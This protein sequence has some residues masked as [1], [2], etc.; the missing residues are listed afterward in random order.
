MRRIRAIHLL[1]LLTV[2]FCALLV[3]DS[4][5]SL[6]GDVPWMSRDEKWIWPYSQPRWDWVVPC[7]LGLALYLV[8]TAYPPQAT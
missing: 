2:L 1:W 5:A 3:T 8:G 7:V 4:Y 6:R